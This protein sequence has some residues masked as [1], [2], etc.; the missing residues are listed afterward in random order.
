MCSVWLLSLSTALTA[1]VAAVLVGGIQVWLREKSYVFSHEEMA[2]IT[3][4]ALNKTCES[5]LQSRGGAR[6]I[7][8][9]ALSRLL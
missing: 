6:P 3:S 2:A 1:V 7:S 4:D 5:Q 8:Y 9:S